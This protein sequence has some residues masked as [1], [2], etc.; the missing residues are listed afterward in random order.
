MISVATC[1]RC[2]ARS[3]LQ[4]RFYAGG[5]RIVP[6][7]WAKPQLPAQWPRGMIT[8]SAESQRKVYGHMKC[9]EV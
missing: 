6:R 8:M 7:H 3:L 4:Q 5:E 1:L 9:L 2:T